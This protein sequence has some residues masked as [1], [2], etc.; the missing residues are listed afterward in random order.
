MTKRKE[1]TEKGKKG[2]LSKN[3]PL[4]FA[5]IYWI[6]PIDLPGFL[7]DIIVTFIAAGLRIWFG[8]DDSKKKK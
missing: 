7:D 1:N 6:N 2:F 8:I 5:L 4:I 3:W